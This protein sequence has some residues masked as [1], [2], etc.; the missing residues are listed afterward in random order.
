MS[1]IKDLL[2]RFRRGP[3]LIAVAITGASNPEL[4]HAPAAGKWNAR[5]IVCHM[6]DSEMV[7]A[8]RFRSIIAQDNPTILGYDQ[9]A[10]ALQLDYQRR[11][12]S[13]ALEIFRTV[14]ANTHDL[15]KHLPEEA[16]ARPCVH[17][18]HG[19]LTLFDLLRIYAEHAEK[20][21]RQIFAA[22]QSYKEARAVQG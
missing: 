5:Q 3:E 6:A 7:A 22:R 18:E 15:L 9:D 16:F 2:E 1:E 13:D 8:Q 14:R 10:W 12:A 11:K 19:P 21:S 17:S 4:D 20:H